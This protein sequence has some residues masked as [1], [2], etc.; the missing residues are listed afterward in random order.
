[1]KMR[2]SIFKISYYF[3]GVCV[4]A[5]GLIVTGC[6]G[7][8]NNEI[9]PL[10]LSPHVITLS[11]SVV[12]EDAPNSTTIG[13]LSVDSKDG[14]TF[15]FSLLDDAEGRFNINGAEL[16]VANSILLDY[17]TALL[18]SITIQATD[19]N[20]NNFTTSL[21]IAVTPK[22]VLLVGRIITVTTA[23]DAENGDVSSVDGIFINPGSDGISL[24]EAIAASNNTPGPETIEFT[25]ELKGSIIQVGS[26]L[27]SRL[28]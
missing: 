23:S 27:Q 11:K 12:S 7:G 6:S 26:Y 16:Q 9:E 1:M 5:L 14:S 2:N 18:H 19:M 28:L 13:V 17:A 21:W 8:S 15:M 3:L 4:I 24:R 10:S 20:E 22:V 25:P